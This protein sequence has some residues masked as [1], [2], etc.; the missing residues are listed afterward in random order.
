MLNIILLF[1]ALFSFLTADPILDLQK[2]VLET[3]RIL[4]EDF[5]EAWN[6]SMIKVDQGYLMTFRYCPDVISQGWVSYIGIVLL[7]E[8]FDP[9]SKPQLLKTRVKNSKT[10]SQSEDARIFKFKD[11]LFLIYHDN[12]DIVYPATW[13]RR[14]MFMSELLFTNNQFTLTPPLK[15]IHE[16]KYNSQT[17]QKNWVPFEKDGVLLMT[18]SI[19]PHEI[20]YT[21]L[22]TGTCYPAY[23]T[24]AE[25]QWDFGILRGSTPPLLVD[26][27]YLAFSHSGII[28]S[29]ESSWGLDLWHYYM[30]AY[31]FSAEPPFEI[32]KMTP[33]PIMHDSFYTPSDYNK[34]V[35]FP[36]GFVV[37][38]SFIYVAYGKDDNEIWIATLDKAM[39]KKALQPVEKAS[40]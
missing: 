14:D 2:V 34:R 30:G 39:L 16:E 9:I 20:L 3:K 27:E 28:T 35:I 7:D 10:P 4:L 26:G 8:A 12:V 25:I 23:E 37:S 29:S 33:V 21:N 32:T 11:R 17:W 18:Y 15:L 31:T 6:P 5:P 22:L 36:G 40:N 38:D 19:N 13:Q 1:T 24:R